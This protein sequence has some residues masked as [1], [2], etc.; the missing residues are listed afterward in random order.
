MHPP[1]LIINQPECLGP[2][3]RL[4]ASKINVFVHIIYVCVYCVYLLCTVYINRRVC[5][6]QKNV[7]FL[8]ITSIYNINHIYIYIY[9]NSTQ[10]YKQ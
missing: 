1:A 8:Y 5:I 9:I 6:F 10:I 7:L 2:V 3:K 4:I